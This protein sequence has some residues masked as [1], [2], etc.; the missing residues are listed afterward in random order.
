MIGGFFSL[1]SE[2]GGRPLLDGSLRAGVW[3]AG[4]VVLGVDRVEVVASLA[5]EGR[6]SFCPEEPLGFSPP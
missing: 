3:V 4:V 5:G 1:L 2:P 6:A